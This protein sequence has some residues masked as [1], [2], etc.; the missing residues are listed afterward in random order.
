MKKLFFR[1]LNKVLSIALWPPQ[2]Q[3]R[4]IGNGFLESLTDGHIHQFTPTFD[5]EVWNAAH[6]AVLA[7]AAAAPPLT[8][9]QSFNKNL[10]E[11]RYPRVQYTRPVSNSCKL[12]LG[13]ARENE[14]A[15]RAILAKYTKDPDVTRMSL[16]LIFERFAI[17]DR[18]GI[19]SILDFHQQPDGLFVFDEE[20]I[21]M[22]SGSGSTRIW[23]YSN[24]VA[25]LKST[26]SVWMS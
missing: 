21:A 15:F 23:E 4:A 19:W 11:A 7:K 9:K 25:T 26:P 20:D 16:D 6:E 5:M 2:R 17:G 8:F 13:R 12:W 22:L 14:E 3:P 18:Y 24:G 1:I 10:M